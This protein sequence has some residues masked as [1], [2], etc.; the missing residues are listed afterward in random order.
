MN[1]GTAM[2]ICS[3]VPGATEV[4]AELGL[5]DHLVGVSHECD[6]P[7]SVRGIPVMVEPL[8]DGAAASREIDH[9]VKTLIA[10]GR[11][12]YRLNEAAFREARPDLVLTQALCH[13][14]AVTP[15]HL[16]GVLETLP[17]RPHILTLNPSSFNDV[18]T[19]V[20]RIA[21]AAGRADAGRSLAGALRDRLARVR[22]PGH[23]P[24]PRVVCLEWL[25]PLYV[26]GHWVPEM[27]EAA[28]GHD[29]LGTAYAPSRETSWRE[30]EA[31]RPD[32][33]IVMPCGYTVERTVQELSRNQSTLDDWQRA[34]HR[35]P[36]VY[37]VDAASYFSR[38]GPRLV[39]GVELLA[40]L[41]RPDTEQPANPRR[42][43]N[44]SATVPERRT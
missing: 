34:L 3:L 32:L 20:E 12:L 10:A 30:I 29:V 41:L 19:D 2:R 35:W 15:D 5:A 16:H 6:F 23:T 1:D 36:T 14:C 44:L 37:A 8:V 27:V 40:S 31:A 11:R 21:A 38:P 39:D 9:Q 24:R 22:P 7:P 13:V 43:V 33:I 18:L 42:A 25:A 17:N 28:G 4:I 26:A